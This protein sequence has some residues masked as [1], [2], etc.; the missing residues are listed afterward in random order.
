MASSTIETSPPETRAARSWWPLSERMIHFV[1]ALGLCVVTWA[2]YDN[3]FAGTFVFDDYPNI[4]DNYR[5]K[6]WHGLPPNLEPKEPSWDAFWNR[7]LLPIRHTQR[8]V[9]YATLAANYLFHEGDPYFY[10][11][12]NFAIH[13]AAGLVLFSLVMKTLTLPRGG[14]LPLAEAR[15]LA[16]AIAALWLVHPL[17]TQ[18]VTY[19]VQRAESLAGLF[20]LLTLYSLVR[21]ATSPRG[22]LEPGWLWGQAAVTS[23]WLGM[24]TKE[25]V[26]TAPVV[27]LLYDRVFL[28]ESWKELLRCRWGLYL[29][30]LAGCWWLI[31][32]I[33]GNPEVAHAAGFG[34]QD[35]S[36]WEYFRSQPAVLLHYLRLVFWPYPQC[37]DPQWMV[38]MTWKG[39]VTPG[40]AVLALLGLSVSLLWRKPPLGF[41]ALSFFLVLAPTSTIVPIADLAF[42]QRMYLP[43][44]CVL[45]LAVLAIWFGAR[46]L[47]RRAPRWTRASEQGAVGLLISALVACVVL[48]ILRN[49]DYRSSEQ[50]WRSV[51]KVVPTS[52]RA[53][54]NLGVS[55]LNDQPLSPE[56]SDEMLA[57]LLESLRLRPDPADSRNAVGRAYSDR[58]DT[59]RAF[60]ALQQ[61]LESDPNYADA[62][63][64]LANLY[65]QQADYQTALK[66]Y[67][68][69]SELKPRLYWATHGLANTLGKLGRYRE[70]IPKYEDVIKRAPTFAP[71][72]CNLGMALLSTGD[73][74]GAKRHLER[75]LELNPI[76]GEAHHGLAAV[77]KLTA[78]T[79][80]E[81]AQLWEHAKLAV[82]YS[83]KSLDAWFHMGNLSAQ[84]G[85]WERARECFH[86]AALLAPTNA[87]AIYNES[88]ALAE[89]GRDAEAV[90]LN[91]EAVRLSPEQIGPQLRLLFFLA[92]HPSPEIRDGAAAVELGLALTTGA[93]RTNP[94]AWDLLAAA[95]AEC[96]RYD[97]A[98][99]AVR[100]AADL[101]VDQDQTDYALE[102][103]ARQQLY[104]L[105]QPYRAGLAELRGQE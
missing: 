104:R 84:A 74:A 27:L 62:H 49:E 78:K 60:D 2:A 98:L 6:S 61:S 99:A 39:I 76:Y 34:F 9:L 20:Y 11:S 50:L 40:L 65:F 85:L 10:H 53:L 18:S 80:A 43:L 31:V 29:G 103:G 21:C 28:A 57:V 81:R 101:A 19:I 92:A 73:V 54:D 52:P 97:E 22:F 88:L 75:A 56:K 71:A 15:W 79:P 94:R 26:F 66:H 1:F 7:A 105:G 93:G 90:A 91:R 37:F 35:V 45:T 32:M 8:P 96:G 46:F 68:R 69:A 67:R 59:K 36:P 83:P 87:D 82:E 51:L 33:V 14:A 13:C 17:Q 70:A 12:L 100:Q 86:E 16:A 23:A 44:A 25:I 72:E 3:S 95:Y 64:N 47:A 42:E 38:V 5:V 41:L 4:L 55:L 30:L 63:H 102:I 77:L 48:T 24:A 58:G 89:L